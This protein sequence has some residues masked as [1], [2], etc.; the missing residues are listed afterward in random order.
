MAG[1]GAALRRVVHDFAAAA[2][3]PDAQRVLEWLD[4]GVGFPATVLDRIVPATTAEDRDAASA[5][6]G[7]RDELAVSGEPY[8]QWVLQDAFPADRPPWELNGAL[9]VP[10]VTPYQLMKLRLLNGSHSA[11][12]Y[13][14]AVAGCR[15]VADVLRTEWGERFVRRF[16][17]EVAPTLPDAGLGVPG[18]IDDLVERYR[19]PEINHQLRQIGSDGSH[20]IPE[21]WFDPLRAL[22]A[23]G[24]GTPMLELS[25]AGWVNATRPDDTPV[26]EV[27]DPASEML[28]ECWRTGES[29]PAPWPGCCG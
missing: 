25:L 7:L 9:L 11:M 22:R 23:A 12:A 10:D 27:V 19:N 8:R 29:A 18:Y 13:L 5:A 21:R 20:K 24:A 14:G 15:T 2:D 1:N 28:A 3:W 6:L 16:A 17:E 26:L 4:R